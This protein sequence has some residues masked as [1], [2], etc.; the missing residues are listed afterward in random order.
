MPV[1]LA[2]SATSLYKHLSCAIV[3]DKTHCKSPASAEAPNH[4]AE[5][6]TQG[7]ISQSNKPARM[8]TSI[9]TSH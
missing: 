3:S 2:S 5:R 1:N 9:P 6:S 7:R 4:S 8:K